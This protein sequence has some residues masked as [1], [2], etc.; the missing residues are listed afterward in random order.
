MTDLEL[1]MKSLHDAEVRCG[2]QSEPPDGGITAWIEC[3]DVTEKVTF[4][5][6][7][8]GDDQVWP[9]AEITK[10]MVETGLRLFPEWPRARGVSAVGR[11]R[12]AGGSARAPELYAEEQAERI[13]R[14]MAAAGKR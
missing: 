7:I 5:G 10:W 13:Y 4:Y 6:H 14:A 11:A 9:T 3:G 8:E 1:I 2:I 12:P